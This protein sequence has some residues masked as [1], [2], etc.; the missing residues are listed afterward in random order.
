M[1]EIL[2]VAMVLSFG[3]AWPTSIAKSLRARTAK[4]KSGFFL[5][6]L[7]FGYAC[8][9]GS[10]IAGGELNYVVI[11]YIINFAMVSID[12]LLFFRNQRIDRQRDQNQQF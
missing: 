8:G 9:I 1:K 4:G 3:A 5:A 12:I 7:L 10:K 6:I 11:F 2:E